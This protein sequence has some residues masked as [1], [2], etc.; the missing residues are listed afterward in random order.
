[1]RQHF[2]NKTTR[3]TAVFVTL[4]ALLKGAGA[5]WERLG[6]AVP[7]DLSV[8]V[9]SS[10]SR[11]PGLEGAGPVDTMHLDLGAR[12]GRMAARQLRRLQAGEA[13]EK[14]VLFNVKHKKRG[15]VRKLERKS[16]G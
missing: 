8:I 3:P 13:L 15:S 9:C 2:A 14:S 16:K 11:M 10:K 12:V 7:G 1:V 6:L 4:S 5:L